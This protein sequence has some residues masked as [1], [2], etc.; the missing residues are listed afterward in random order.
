M[1]WLKVDVMLFRT[2]NENYKSEVNSLIEKRIK[3]VKFFF[4]NLSQL[5]EDKA[6][7]N[8][9]NQIERLMSIIKAKNKSIFI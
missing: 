4:F 6:K 3:E 5:Y 9:F 8:T 1:G 2:A 7:K